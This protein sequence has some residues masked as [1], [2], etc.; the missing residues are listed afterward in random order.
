MAEPALIT[1]RLSRL[2]SDP[3]LRAFFE[4]GEQESGD[5]FAVPLPE[6]PELSGGAVLEP[7]A[8]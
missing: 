6:T 7:Q 5:E 2:V 3:V 4:R 8:V 1:I